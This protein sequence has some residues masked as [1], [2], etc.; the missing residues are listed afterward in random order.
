MKYGVAWY[1][2]VL[3]LEALTSMGSTKDNALCTVWH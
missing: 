3:S 2:L 1:H